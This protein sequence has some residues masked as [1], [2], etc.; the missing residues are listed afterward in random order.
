MRKEMETFKKLPCTFCAIESDCWLADANNC[1]KFTYGTHGKFD[2]YSVAYRKIKDHPVFIRSLIDLLKRFLIEY[3]DH[4]LFIGMK[5]DQFYLKA[6]AHL[7][8]NP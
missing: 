2:I 7:K 4:R 5:G 1:Y 3:P 8:S 6:I